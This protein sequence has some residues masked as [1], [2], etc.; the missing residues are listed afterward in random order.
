MK[1]IIIFIL[2]F[3]ALP[4]YAKEAKE[5]NTGKC[6]KQS[7]YVFS[8]GSLVNYSPYTLAVT[9]IYENIDGNKTTYSSI[10]CQEMIGMTSPGNISNVVAGSGFNYDVTVNTFI[11]CRSQFDYDNFNDKFKN[12]NTIT[13]EAMTEEYNLYAKWTDSLDDKIVPS[14]TKSISVTIDDSQTI[15]SSIN[16]QMI[17]QD[18]QVT[19]I[20]TLNNKKLPSTTFSTKLGT[21]SIWIK[22]F[23]VTSTYIPIAKKMI[24]SG[25]DYGT[26]VKGEYVTKDRTTNSESKIF[27]DYSMINNNYSLMVTVKNSN[28][29]W[30]IVSNCGY[31]IYNKGSVSKEKRLSF[32]QISLTDPFPNGVGANWKNLEG[33]ITG[34]EFDLDPV[35][36]VQ[37]DRDSIN[38]IREYNDDYTLDNS[39]GYATFVDMNINDTTDNTKLNAYKSNFINSTFKNIFTKVGD[40]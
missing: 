23:T 17:L 5:Y 9:A 25:P 39:N 12:A 33:L 27:T 6:L 32:R 16:S 2:L 10:S 40:N 31:N 24:I 13:K 34:E 22:A 20:K 14:I 4:V 19:E 8:D 7:G 1:K 26:I 18:T 21:A 28:K 36:V 29:S 11:V 35:Y 15:N 3:F 30:T 37:M 38:K